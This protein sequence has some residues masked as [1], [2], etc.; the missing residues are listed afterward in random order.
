MAALRQRGSGP[1][2]KAGKPAVGRVTISGRVF[3]EPGGKGVGDIH[4]TLQTGLGYGVFTKTASDG[5]YSMA[6]ESAASKR[7][8][9]LWI[10]AGSRPQARGAPACGPMWPTRI[11]PHRICTCGCRNRFPERSVTRKPASRSPASQIDLA[12]PHYCSVTTD[13]EGRYRF[14]LPPG[15]VGVGC[16][17]ALRRRKRRPSPS[18]RARRSKNVDLQ[19]RTGPALAEPLCCPMAVRPRT[20]WYT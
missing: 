12:A 8:M 6:V 2:D 11:S 13:D 10:D 20:P 4:L 14:Y 9:N 17:G 1:D 3:D 7:S 15:T 16:R 18:P 5:S 19:L